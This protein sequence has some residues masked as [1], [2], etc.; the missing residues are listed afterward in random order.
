MPIRIAL[1]TLIALIATPA[2]AGDRSERRQNHR[3]AAD[4]GHDTR[5]DARDLTRIDAIATDWRAARRAGDRIAEGNAD[6]RLERW[7]R[8]ELAENQR[9]VAEARREVGR[10]QSEVNASR[11][12]RNRTVGTG[13]PVRAADDRRDL[14][15]DRR[16]RADDQRD[17]SNEKADR[18]RTRRLATQLRDMQPRFEAGTASPAD[19]QAKS[20]VLDQ[21]VALS[22]AE[23]RRNAA[24]NRED[25]R[26]R[27]EDRRER[28]ER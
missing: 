17:L 11:R 1:L 26:E 18:A 23:V 20:E 25:S 8:Q 6:A 12:E 10:S 3:E 4:N 24:E 21:L 28:R 9:D 2:F 19:Y 13:R 14:R 27:R 22:V 5:N 16:D 15:D 7:I